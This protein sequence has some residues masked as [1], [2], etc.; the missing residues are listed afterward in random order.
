MSNILHIRSLCGFFG[1]QKDGP[2]NRDFM[3]CGAG[4]LREGREGLQVIEKAVAYTKAQ[5]PADALG[6]KSGQI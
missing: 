4:W 1:R 5:A 2:L 6:A 3:V